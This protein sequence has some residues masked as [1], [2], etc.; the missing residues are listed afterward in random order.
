MDINTA[1]ENIMRLVTDITFIPFAVGFVVVVT[2]IIKAFTKWEGNRAALVAL[3]VQ[4]VVW[5][6][7]AIAKAQGVDGQF[8]TWVEAAETILKTL[9]TV[10]LPAILSGMAAQS[11]YDKATDKQVAGFRKPQNPVV[12]A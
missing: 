5:I 6:G 2:Q 1:F 8:Q 7:Y 10:L 11:V 4:A 9:A 3:V 12:A